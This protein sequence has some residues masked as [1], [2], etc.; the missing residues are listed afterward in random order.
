[1]TSSSARN[2]ESIRETGLRAWTPLLLTIA[3]FAGLGSLALYRILQTPSPVAQA[4]IGVCAALYVAWMLWESRVSVREISKEAEDHDHGTMEL[5][6]AVKIALLLSALLFPSFAMTARTAAVTGGLALALLIGGIALRRAAIRALGE[7]YSHRIRTPRFPLVVRGPYAAIRHPAYA[8]TLLIHSAVVLVMP[9]WFSCALLAVWFA[10]VWYRTRVEE[11]WLMN[12][13]EYREYAA[14]VPGLW[15]PQGHVPLLLSFA[16]I[17][18]IC[19]SAAYRISV[20][21]PA[22]ALPLSAVIAAYLAWILLEGRVAAGEVSRNATR[23]DR[24]TCE[25]YAFGRAATVLSAIWAGPVADAP[26][27][28]YAAGLAV[29]VSGVVFRL[30]AIRVLGRFYSHRVRLSESH[31]VVSHGPYRIVRHPAYTGMIAAHAGVTMCFFNWLSVALLLLVLVPAVVL[32]IHVEERALFA[33]RGYP[34]Y[35]AGRRRLI[36]LVW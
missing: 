20:L 3:G 24:G 13:S 30:V 1:V 16:L 14:S 31:S 26:G 25:L 29:F 33:L 19:G 34:E 22:W 8:G 5:C 28:L 15:L 7:S 27:A 9:N 6:A 4:G 32:R 21:P 18:S 10:A 36:P 11:R 17:A 12:Y 35:A 2:A 23:I